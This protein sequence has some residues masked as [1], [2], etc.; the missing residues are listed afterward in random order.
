MPLYSMLTLLKPTAHV[1]K[2]L[3]N[4]AGVVSMALVRQGGVVRSIL[5]Q[6]VMPLPKS[7]RCS[8]TFERFKRAR[9]VTYNFY[10]SPQAMK[11]VEHQWKAGLGVLRVTLKKE[12]DRGSADLEQRCLIRS[13][14]KGAFPTLAD[15]PSGTN[16][17]G[18]GLGPDG[19]KHGPLGPDLGLGEVDGVDYADESL[20]VEEDAAA[21]A[22]AKR[23]KAQSKQDK[24]AIAMRRK[25]NQQGR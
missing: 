21:R 3:P 4:T 15:F 17:L 11:E 6:G 20:F 18:P 14:Q 2:M 7:V 10:G 9:I 16:F 22:A 13:P 24:E 5:D 19:A 25:K 12:S 1:A 23:A 8:D